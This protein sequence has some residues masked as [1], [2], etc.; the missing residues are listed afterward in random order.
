LKYRPIIDGM[1][2]DF[3]ALELQ[4]IPRKPRVGVVGEILVKFQP[5]ANNNL[6]GLLEAEGCEVVL[7]GLTEFVLNGAY[8]ADWNYQNL[9]TD[10]RA[11]YVK[12]FIVRLIEAY[13]APIRR[14]LATSRGKF[15]PHSDIAT[16]AQKAAEIVSL[17]NQAGEGWLLTAE[18]VDLVTHGVPNVVCAQ[19]FAC[20]P[21]HVTGKGV[22]GEIRRRYPQANIATIEYD[23]GASEVNQLNRVKLLVSTAHQVHNRVPVAVSPQVAPE[24]VDMSVSV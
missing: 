18:I 10:Q 8:T 11:R 16:M 20:L 21:N 4:D 13:R 9:G 17:G 14:A 5:D 15:V 22:F 24:P 23:P 3:D 12:R 6:I 7:P 19:P 2:R 1:I